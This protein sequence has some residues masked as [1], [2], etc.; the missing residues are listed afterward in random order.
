M[1]FTKLAR[2]FVKGRFIVR[3]G[4]LIIAIHLLSACQMLPSEKTKKTKQPEAEQAQA[5][6]EAE[7]PLE[8]LPNPY[9]ENKVSVPGRAQQEF[10]RAQAA[11]QNKNWDAAE[12]LL[13][14]MVETYPKLSGPYVNL[15][16]VQRN[17]N[18]PEEAE[19]AFRFALE[20]NPYN[21]DAYSQLGL[22]L[23]EQGKFSE[24]EQVYLKALQVWP[25]HF[26]SQKN[27][28]VLY[29]LYMGRLPEALEHY[30]MARRILREPDRQLEGWIV[31]LERRIESEK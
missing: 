27:L 17:K 31:D 16:I 15:G 9:L 26:D 14:L 25:H 30:K 23:R 11:M 2:H 10:A 24:A 12:S 21:M 13:T 19:K 20:T 29:D 8:L 7:P 3:V 6:G 18:K 5:E 1:V 28:G 4:V 22:L